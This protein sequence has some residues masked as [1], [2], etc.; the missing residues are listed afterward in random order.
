MTCFAR[1]S[2]ASD[3][4]ARE[5]GQPANALVTMLVRAE[6]DR[7]LPGAREAYQRRG[8]LVEQLL[9]RRG[10]DPDSAD[11]QA[12]RRHARSMFDDADNPPP[13]PHRM[14]DPVLLLDFTVPIAY[15][16]N[17]TRRAHALLLEALLTGG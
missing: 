2:A 5:R 4:S 14:T 6:L 7:A 9:R 10:V 17:L 12:A 3:S 15:E 1:P 11:Y 13:R 16:R 8:E